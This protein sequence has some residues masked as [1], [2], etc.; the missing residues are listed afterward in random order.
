MEVR[1]DRLL[2]RADAHVV[3]AGDDDGL[4]GG[5]NPGT[6]YRTPPLVPDANYI[7]WR[8]TN[9]LVAPWT[10]LN[11]HY[12]NDRVKATVQIASYNLTDPGYR[13]LESNLGH[14]PGVHHD[15]LCPSSAATRTS[16]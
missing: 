15:E 6:Q 1:R 13:R 5:G 16:T 14:Q 12:G 3:G 9:S 2:P 4:A 11:F 10:E 7:D 8:Y